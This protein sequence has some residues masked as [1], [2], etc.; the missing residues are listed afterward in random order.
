MMRSC[1]VSIH[2]MCRPQ[3]VTPQ[4]SLRGGTRVLFVGVVPVSSIV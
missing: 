1:L 3:L 2:P 4:E